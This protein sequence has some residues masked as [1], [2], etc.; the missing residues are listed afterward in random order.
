MVDERLDAIRFVEHAIAPAL[1]QREALAL[2]LRSFRPRGQR[3][4]NRLGI[5]V[6]HEPPDELQLTPARLVTVQRACKRNGVDQSL[7][8][9]ERR[10]PR[11]IERDEL[12]A[13]RLQRMHFVLAPRLRR[14]CARVVCGSRR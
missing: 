9:I 4:A 3:C 1:D 7:G 13:Q 6:A 12:D 2:V 11:R 5:D 10:K 14:G 8:Q